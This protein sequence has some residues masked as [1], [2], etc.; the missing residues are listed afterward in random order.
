MAAED[1]LVG[2]DITLVIG[3]TEVESVQAIAGVTSGDDVVKAEDNT[4]VEDAFTGVTSSQP[5]QITL[6]VA[7]E[8]GQELPQLGGAPTQ[9][10][11][12]SRS[13]SSMKTSWWSDLP[14]KR[15][16]CSF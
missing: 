4:T 10:W 6:V 13:L 14:R 5:G 3:T 8:Q 11:R 15:P 1:A 16:C 12:L 9:G 2:H 7:E